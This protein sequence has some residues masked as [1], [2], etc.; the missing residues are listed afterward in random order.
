M[1]AAR[2]RETSQASSSWDLVS[3]LE[4]GTLKR[5]ASQREQLPKELQGMDENQLTK[6]LDS[7]LAERKSVREQISRLQEDRRVYL[8][9]QE[10][11]SAQA[12]TLDRA[13]IDAIRK[14]ASA[15]GFTFK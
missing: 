8:A 5:S 9:Q 6:H 10:K 13:M 11:V 7:K 1:A 2:A 3:A 12:G 14:Q 4:S 15:R